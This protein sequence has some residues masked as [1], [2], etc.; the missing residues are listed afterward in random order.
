VL[1]VGWQ[2]RFRVGRLIAIFTALGVGVALW[3]QPEFKSVARIMPEM[4]SGSGDMLKRLASVAGFSGTDFSDAEDIDAVRPDLYPNVL[5]STPFVLYLM[6][7][8]VFTMDR[9]GKTVGKLLR[10]NSE[11]MSWM[12]RIF[13]LK[14]DELNIPPKNR[15]IGTVRLSAWQ[16]EV[17]EEISERV[18]AKLDTRS[19]IITITATMPDANVAATVAQLAMNYLTDYVINYRTEKVR[20]DLAF[21]RHRL[22]EARERYHKAQFSVF[23][24]NDNH[25]AIVRQATTMNRHRMEAELAIAQTVYTELAQQFEQTTLK[26]QARTPVFK[27]LEPPRVPLKRASPKR[28]LLVLL[29]A[30]TG[31]LAGVLLALARQNNLI[32]QLR[33]VLETAPS[34]T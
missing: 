19:G 29:F 34:P 22:T 27:V 2:N 14:A 9:Q 11:S 6:N 31:L 3:M 23:Q 33:M 28:T 26:V 8:P 16:Q 18:S 21:Y 17:A 12:K 30:L 25:K 10:P 1:R 24:Y 4:N 7:Q 20:N 13:P 15:T 5:Q 32:G